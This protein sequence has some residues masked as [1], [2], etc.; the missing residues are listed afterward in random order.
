MNLQHIRYALEVN[1]TGSITQAAENLYMN[2]PNLSKAI[3]E[4]EEELGYKIFNRT[5]KGMIPTQKGE[6]FLIRGKKIL[7][8]IKDL[9]SLFSLVEKPLG[10]SVV[11]P[12]YFPLSNIL[13]AMLD[14]QEGKEE[15]TW[16]IIEMDDDNAI[17][18]IMEGQSQLGILRYSSIYDLYVGQYLKSKGI[19]SKLLAHNAKSVVFSIESPLNR[20]S[21]LSPENVRDQIEL[22]LYI[23]PS[24]HLPE[25]SIIG[26]TSFNEPGR[27]KRTFLFS[28]TLTALE[29]LVENPNTY[30]IAPSPLPVTTLN[31]YKL[32]QKLHW[33]ESTRYMNRLIYGASHGFSHEEESFIKQVLKGF[34][35]ADATIL[36]QHTST[37]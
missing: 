16:H 6:I 34:S 28:D 15:T 30:M 2:Q 12:R 11:V 27:E 26:E 32:S 24:R 1:R 31:R 9:E 21:S 19:K 23:Q 22:Q 20:L 5:T 33:D 17:K 29:V 7:S 4:F 37:E 25:D 14:S 13:N 35:E 10:F 8:D 36:Y 18:Q 3:R